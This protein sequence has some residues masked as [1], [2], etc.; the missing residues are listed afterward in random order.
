MLMYYSHRLDED[1]DDAVMPL[2][3]LK[4]LQA[5]FSTCDFWKFNKSELG[6]LGFMNWSDEFLLIPVWA[7]PIILKNSKNKKVY[8]PASQE[9]MIRDI[10]VHEKPL[11]KYGCVPYGFKIE[12]LK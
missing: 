8:T 2:Y 4:D 11:I 5:A 1:N 9:L 3:N 6:Q 10:D 12:E 7:F